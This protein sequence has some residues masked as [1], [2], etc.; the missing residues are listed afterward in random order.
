MDFNYFYFPLFQDLED[1]IQIV[2]KNPSKFRI[3][4]QELNSR[5][6]FI[7]QTREEVNEMKNRATTAAAAATTNNGAAKFSEVRQFFSPLVR[8]DWI[9]FVYRKTAFY[10]QDILNKAKLVLK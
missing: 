10:C 9:L 8:I 2:E 3:E 1:T 5:K 6:L 4:S 7:Q